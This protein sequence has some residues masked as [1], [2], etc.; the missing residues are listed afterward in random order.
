MVTEVKAIRAEPPPAPQEV[1]VVQN[2]PWGSVDHNHE[3]PKRKEMFQRAKDMD[4][5]Q[6]GGA[7]SQCEKYLLNFFLGMDNPLY[8]HAPKQWKYN[9]DKFQEE[10]WKAIRNPELLQQIEALPMHES[11]CKL[12]DESEDDPAKRWLLKPYHEPTHIRHSCCIVVTTGYR[13]LLR[14]K[15]G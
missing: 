15:T 8:K 4:K 10:V 11:L 9:G 1:R 14:S 2:V 12:L 6:N 3:Y 13:L 7:Y 5:E